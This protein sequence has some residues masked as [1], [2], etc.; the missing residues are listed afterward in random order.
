[1][2]GQPLSW[3]A[4]YLDWG[5]ALLKRSSWKM[6]CSFMAGFLR[7]GQRMTGLLHEK[8]AVHQSYATEE[9]DEFCA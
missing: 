4:P 6:T 7:S 1:M 2:S 9:P 8:M 5:R 3:S